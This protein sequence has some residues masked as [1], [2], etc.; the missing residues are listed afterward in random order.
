ME[1][2]ITIPANIFWMVMAHLDR[3]VEN[4]TDLAAKGLAKAAIS[5]L[6]TYDN[7]EHLAKEFGLK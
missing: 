5:T 1:K 2:N 7:E 6:K 4:P 3:F